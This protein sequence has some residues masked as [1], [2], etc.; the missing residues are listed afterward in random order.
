ML[1]GQG[2]IRFFANVR[3]ISRFLKVPPQFCEET[4]RQRYEDSSSSPRVIRICYICFHFRYHYLLQSH[5][6]KL[7]RFFHLGGSP[8]TEF[9][10]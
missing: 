7:I 5:D 10:N 2:E 4:A 6:F 8:L 1:N 9:G 3:T